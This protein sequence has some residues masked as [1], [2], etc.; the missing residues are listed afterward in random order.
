MTTD[1][2]LNGGIVAGG[3]LTLSGDLNASGEGKAINCTSMIASGAVRGASLVIAGNAQA[4]T[5]TAAGEIS[6]AANMIT[7]LGGFAILLKNSTGAA[8]IKGTIVSIKAGVDSEFEL[9]PIDATHCLGV[10]E[11]DAVVDGGY[12]FVTVAG[13]APVLMKNAATAGHIC[14]IPLSTDEGEVAGY[15]MDAVQSTSASVYKIGDILET[16]NADTLC[17]V[18][19]S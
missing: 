16:K 19:L 15:A 10:V 11:S 3:D 1:L 12:A 7:T 13:M 4:N 9:T 8:T 5:L 6:S 18:R 2:T 17:L 14:R